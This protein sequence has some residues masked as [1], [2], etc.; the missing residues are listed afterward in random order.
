MIINCLYNPKLK[1]RL[2]LS[3]QQKTNRVP[4]EVSLVNNNAYGYGFWKF[5]G[6]RGPLAAVVVPAPFARIPGQ[7]VPMQ[8]AVVAPVSLIY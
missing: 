2:L 4:F 6:L 7:N 5:Y 1:R 8:A 3:L